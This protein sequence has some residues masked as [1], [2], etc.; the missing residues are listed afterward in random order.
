MTAARPSRAQCF[1]RFLEALALCSLATFA[2]PST[3]AHEQS[4]RFGDID[5][6]VWTPEA[7]AN[8]PLPVIV[9]SHG[10][11]TCATQSRFLTEALA[12]AGY[13]VI[14]PNHHDASCAM[15]FGSFGFSRLPGKPAMFWTD[16]DYRDRADDIRN[17]VATLRD[18][19]RFRGI[20]DVSR[21]AL[22]GH[23]L[24]GYTVLGL[25]G[26]WPKWTLPGVQAVLAF[27]PYAMPFAHSEGMRH[28]Q[29]PVMFQAGQFDPVFTGP[30]QTA[31]DQSPQPKY[32]VEIEHAFHLAWADLGML[33]PRSITTYALAFFDR[34]LKDASD[35]SLLGTQQAHAAAMVTQ[36]VGGAAALPPL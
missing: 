3:A 12:D 21:L 20:A 8:K 25:A 30:M 22:M 11:Y 31:Y 35:D 7:N 29:A 15:T 28:L 24:G 36:K 23:S 14:A 10:L 6:V 27:A 34:Y 33:H 32:F 4:F 26:A 9:F 16:E 5:A 2:T 19:A 1:T 17:L 13:F 18:D